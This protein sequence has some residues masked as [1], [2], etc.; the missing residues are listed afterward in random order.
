MQ[1]KYKGIRERLK[2]HIEDSNGEGAW[3]E[4]YGSQLEADIVRFVEKEQSFGKTIADEQRDMRRD[5]FEEWL[6]TFSKQNEM[7]DFTSSLSCCRNSMRD[8][9]NDLEIGEF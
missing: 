7:Y 4:Y 6:S 1:V 9:Y 3:K 8:K 2:K 5:K